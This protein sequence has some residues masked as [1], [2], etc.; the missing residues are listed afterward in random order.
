MNAN[1]VIT[2]AA[3]TEAR[4]R[5]TKINSMSSDEYRNSL[6]KLPTAAVPKK[7]VNYLLRGLV[8]I[9]FLAFWQLS[10]WLEI[11][12]NRVIPSPSTVLESFSELL[13]S[14][15]LFTA[16]GASLARAGTGLAIALAVG[17]SFGVA[18]ALSKLSEVL[19]DSTFQIIRVIPFIALAPLFIIWFGI[20]E[21]FK[22]I[23]IAVA[24]VYPAYL[25]TYAAVRQVDRR[26]IETGS[27]FGLTN[28]QIIGRIILP[29]ASPGILVGI[30]LA[31]GVTLLAL[32]VAEQVNASSGI[33]FLIYLAQQSFRID[34]IIVGII[35]YA[36]L[37]ILIDIVMR[38]LERSV[39]P[40]K[41]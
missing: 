26:L 11:S 4:I 15:T 17:I 5:S 16:L 33:G 24:G 25:N 18:N 35:V 2:L 14:G 19:T 34:I 36:I 13:G 30:R 21:E 7:N 20:G 37:G 39:N 27:A 1:K 32:I 23:L 31:M 10:S 3:S 28:L 9:L 40:W 41:Y 8:P 22:I 12:D 38:L 29:A 6:Q